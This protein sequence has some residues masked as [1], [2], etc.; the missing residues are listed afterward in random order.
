M[1]LRDSVRD[2]LSTL[3]AD[4]LASWRDHLLRDLRKAGVNLGACAFLIGIS[5]GSTNN[6]TPSGIGHLIRY[7][8][9][10]L[11]ETMK[12]VAGR[13]GELLTVSNESVTKARQFRRAA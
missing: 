5:D 4:E 2:A 11:P 7:V 10:N 6:L 12:V 1:L 8:R 9:L 13:L 3:T